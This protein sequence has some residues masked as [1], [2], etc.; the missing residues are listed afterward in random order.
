MTFQKD[1]YN[2]FLNLISPQDEYAY[3]LLSWSLETF[4][5][6]VYSIEDTKPKKPIAKKINSLT[7][8]GNNNAAL[9]EFILNLSNHY[10]ATPALVR[11]GAGVSLHSAVKIFPKLIQGNRG[12]YQFIISGCLD[13]DFL[14]SFLFMTLLP[15]VKE[16]EVYA[17]PTSIAPERKTSS[18]RASMGTKPTTAIEVTE[19]VKIKEMVDKL[20]HKATKISY[21]M[22]YGCEI[23]TEE[24]EI[25]IGMILDKAVLN[26]P[27]LNAKMLH[28]MAN[29]L[30]YL[31]KPM[32]LK[33]LELIRVWAGRNEKVKT[34]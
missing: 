17:P 27:P 20:C 31:A 7:T 29:S 13:P 15:C 14:T 18:R 22:L 19:N 23:A 33:Q 9:L 10:R 21:D 32:K 4:T 8:I 1:C 2:I 11:Y 3:D 30:E 24:T 12:L 28:K 16:E 5:E 34:K 6:K 25:S 26:S